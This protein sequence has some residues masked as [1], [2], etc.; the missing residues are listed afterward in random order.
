MCAAHIHLSFGTDAL[1]VS[2]LKLKR[3]CNN[4]VQ[5]VPCS[6]NEFTE[7]TKNI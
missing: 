6:S 7:K 2:G 5:F 4:L 1:I 3:L